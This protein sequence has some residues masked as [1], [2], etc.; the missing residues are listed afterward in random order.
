MNTDRDFDEDGNNIVPCPICLDI[1]CPSKDN[2]KCPEEDDFINAMENK[3]QSKFLN[4]GT[5]CGLGDLSMMIGV[6]SGIMD[7]EVRK[8]VEAILKIIGDKQLN[9]CNCITKG[10]RGVHVPWCDAV[11]AR[12]RIK[13]EYRKKIINKISIIKK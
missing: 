13:E 10:Q 11:N 12:L 4:K 3:W 7:E 8:A 1:Y 9:K 2:G 5:E 6:V